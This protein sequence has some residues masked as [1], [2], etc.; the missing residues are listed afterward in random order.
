M[1]GFR[2]YADEAEIKDIS[3][4]VY[5]LGTPDGAEEF[6]SLT[7]I[8]A[9]KL[10]FQEGINY[11]GTDND[12]RKRV[13]VL[14]VSYSVPIAYEGITPIAKIFKSAWER[15]VEGWN[16]GQDR[17]VTVETEWNDSR[18]EL[19]GGGFENSSGV[20]ILSTSNTLIF[21]IVR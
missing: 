13:L 10:G 9:D 18:S 4:R 16:N 6:E 17:N 2:I 7:S 8:K 1:N 12:E 21:Y 3:Y 19:S 5:D 20:G 15:E 14:G 11:M